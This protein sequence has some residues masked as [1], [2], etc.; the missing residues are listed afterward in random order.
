MEQHNGHTGCFHWKNAA[1][2]EMQACI[3]LL[4][5]APVRFTE[6]IVGTSGL[7]HQPSCVIVWFHHVDI[8]IIST[9]SDVQ[10]SKSIVTEMMIP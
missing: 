3:L 7:L 10:I 2:L 9:E 8:I 5:S 1:F 6:I 4:F